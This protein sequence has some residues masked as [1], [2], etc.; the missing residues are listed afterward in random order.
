MDLFFHIYK[1]IF[2]LSLNS[3]YWSICIIYFSRLPISTI[4]RVWNCT[5]LCCL[6][7]DLKIDPESIDRQPELTAWSWVIAS[8]H[9]F[10]M[11]GTTSLK[12]CVLVFFVICFVLIFGGYTPAHRYSDA[13]GSNKLQLGHLEVWGAHWREKSVGVLTA[14]LM[15]ASLVAG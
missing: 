10:V 5:L 11:A 12:S 2:I 15:E 8:S 3:I 14:Q 1:K 9:Y 13:G 6:L 4:T 7:F